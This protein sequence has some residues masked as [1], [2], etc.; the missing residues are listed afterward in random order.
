MKKILSLMTLTLFLGVIA[1]PVLAQDPPKD[2]QKTEAKKDCPKKCEKA[3]TKADS[4][5]CEKHQKAGCC[6]GDKK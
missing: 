3:C 2:K 5:K 1:F 6:K 4:T